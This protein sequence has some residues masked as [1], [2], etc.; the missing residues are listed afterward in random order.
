[1]QP[2]LIWLG[3]TVAVKS[4]SPS[5]SGLS[6]NL[7]S[8]FTGVL[9]IYTPCIFYWFRREKMDFLTGRSVTRSILWFAAISTLSAGAFVI[10]L[11][12][13]GGR[14]IAGKSHLLFTRKSATF[15]ASSLFIVALPEEFFFRG[16]L[17]DRIK[18]KEWVKIL[19]TSVLFSITHIAVGFS[20]F[21]LLTF[22]PGIAL[23]YLRSKT[24][25]VYTPAILHN[26]FN[27][28]HWASSV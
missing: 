13:S 22:F 14:F 7:S 16:F 28:I 12:I 5:F 24:G 25:E 20:L 10:F 26:L 19:A 1:M 15:W 8:L 4:I 23:G 9:L 17:Y 27:L 18:G 3:V 6:D 21:R 11:K 2:Y